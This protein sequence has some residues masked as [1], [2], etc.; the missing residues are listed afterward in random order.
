LSWPAPKVG[1]VIRYAYLWK[2]EADA[3]LEEGLKD[4]PAAI[5][6]AQTREGDEIRVVVA[7]ITH[8]PPIQDDDGVE[9]PPATR[10]R[11]GLDDERQ[12]IILGELNSFLWPG[13][14][15]RP[16]PGEGPDS[17]IVG[18][19]PAALSTLLNARLRARIIARRVA[20]TTRTGTE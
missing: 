18:E 20:I 10:R 5:V 4:R 11:V 13:P 1:Q 3:G 8:T 14:D 6:I 12:W 19:L 7:P 17:V 16:T 9:V 15:L 2:S